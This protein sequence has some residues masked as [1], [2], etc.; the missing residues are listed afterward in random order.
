MIFIL[1]DDSAFSTKRLKSHPQP[2]L[3]SS[4]YKVF[5]IRI[6]AMIDTLQQVDIKPTLLVMSCQ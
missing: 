5:I 6:L 4:N 3:E 1:T 2:F